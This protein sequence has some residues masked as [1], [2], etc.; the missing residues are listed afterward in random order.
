M[1]EVPAATNATETA[2]RTMVWIFGRCHPQVAG[3]AVIL[4]ELN[5]AVDAI[6]SEIGDPLASHFSNH[7]Q[8]I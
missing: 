4:T 2:T 1:L 8:F 3:G 5:F 7:V 6:I